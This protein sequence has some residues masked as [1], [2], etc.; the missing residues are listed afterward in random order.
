MMARDPGDAHLGKAELPE[1]LRAPQHPD[2]S[3]YEQYFQIVRTRSNIVSWTRTCLRVQ[4]AVLEDLADSD[5]DENDRIRL[6][7]GLALLNRS[8]LAAW[9]SPADTS[10]P[11][12][13]RAPCA[14]AALEEERSAA[15]HR[16]RIGHQLFH[17][18]LGVMITTLDTALDAAGCGRH[19]HLAVAMDEL[20]LL[21][22]AATA[23]M[24]YTAG[25]P[26][27]AYAREV[28]PT[29]E[30]PFLPEGFSGVLNREHSTMTTKLRAL[31][32][33]LKQLPQPPKDGAD[34]AAPTARLREARR[35]NQ[36]NH[37]AICQR[38]VPD[39]ASL[40]Q[41]YLNKKDTEKTTNL[42]QPS[43][44]PAPNTEC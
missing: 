16:W 24:S 40:L 25:F 4:G 39:G 6:L 27:T 22:D 33:A 1:D 30:P 15:L 19:R 5:L 32:Q 3:D 9:T 18:Q 8:A 13:E 41:S 7:A 10:S 42:D 28:R 31:F 37:M 36:A 34:L 12:A 2:Y 38:F 44:G 23:T 17:L 11:D 21:Y 20:S 35:R 26:P 43:G 14:D 29:M